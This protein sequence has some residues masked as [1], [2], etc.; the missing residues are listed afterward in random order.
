MFWHTWSG[1]LLHQDGHLHPSDRPYPQF[2]V[3]SKLCSIRGT[4]SAF[5][6]PIRSTFLVVDICPPV[7]RID[8]GVTLKN[9]AHLSTSSRFALPFMAGAPRLQWRA[10]LHELKDEK[11]TG[12]FDPAVNI[13]LM[14]TPSGVSVTASAIVPI[15]HRECCPAL[16]NM[17]HPWRSAVRLPFN[18]LVPG[19][20]CRTIGLS[21]RSCRAGAHVHPG[22]YE[23][24]VSA[25]F[26][27]DHD[28]I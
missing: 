24:A 27:M 22:T 11:R 14:T 25:P 7:M 6:V 26:S 9:L 1:V 3:F 16:T 2:P 10:F 15:D 8:A 21:R 19:S 28:G 17:D 4:I 18:A 23:C 12:C 20:A 5:V 13:T